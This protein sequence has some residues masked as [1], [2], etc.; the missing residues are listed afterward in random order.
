MSVVAGTVV[1]GTG[2]FRDADGELFD[3]VS[4]ICYLENQFKE[5]VTDTEEATQVSEGVYQG[6]LQ[7]PKDLNFVYFVFE[8]TCPSEEKYYGREKI[9]LVYYL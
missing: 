4:V 2:T 6:Y 3:P 5:V 1:R 9:T 8:G 7:T